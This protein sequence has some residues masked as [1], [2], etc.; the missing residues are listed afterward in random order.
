[1]SENGNDLEIL[2]TAALDLKKTLETVKSQIKQVQSSLKSE[3]IE[4][5]AGLSNSTKQNL[6]KDLNDVTNVKSDG[7]KQV[8]NNLDQVGR[9][10][11]TTAANLTLAHQAIIGLER[12]ARTMVTT[13][14]ELDKQ[15][16]GLRMVTGDSYDDASRLV[17][18]Y[19]V[20]ARELGS[21][22]AQVIDAAD[23]WL[24][25]GK[26]VSETETLIQQSM[27]LSKVGAMDSAMATESL[28]SAMKGYGLAVDD[29]AGIVD[30]LTAIDLKAAVTASD[31]AT[32]MSR[33]A[34]SANISGVKM[35][36]LLGYIAT[37]EEV[38]QKSAETIGNSFQTI[39]ARMGNVK[40]GKFLSDDGEDLSDVEKILSHFGIALRD[41]NEQ[42]RDFGEV[43]DDVAAKWKNF[44][45]VDQNALATTIAGTRQREN[46]LVLM[47]NYSK[48]ME[49]AAV[50]AE[51]TGTAQ[52]KFDAYLDSMEAH[53]NTL[54]ASAEALAKQT[55]STDFLNGL[56]DAG[57]AILDFV[58]NA[59]L[60]TVALTALGTAFAIKGVASFVDTVKKAYDHVT[61]LSQAFDILSKSS[62]VALSADEFDKLLSVTKSLNSSQMELVVTNQALTAEQRMALLTA[63][64]LTAEEAKQ[65]LTTMGLATAEGTATAATFSLSGA[66][67]ALGAAIAANP[68]GLIA[69][70]LTATITVVSAVNRHMDELRQATEEASKAFD[71]QCQSIEDYK[72]KI[73]ELRGEL[74]SGNLSE[75]EAYDKRQ[76]L[77]SIQDEIV[78]KLGSEAG[79]FNILKDS[80]DSVNAAL[81]GFT[82][83]EARAVLTQNAREYE[84]AVG[85]MERRG[86]TALTA[87]DNSRV[88]EVF[89]EVFGDKVSFQEMEN[90]QIAYYLDVNA[91]DA[92]EGLQKVNDALYDL[93]KEFDGKGWD[94]NN[95]LDLDSGGWQKKLAKS[96]ENAQNVI[97]DYGTNYNAFIQNTIRADEELLAVQGKVSD[98]AEQ[99]RNALA[100]GDDEITLSLYESFSDILTELP[101]D[102]P[103]S[104]R[105]YFEQLVDDLQQESEKYVLKIQLEAELETDESELRKQ[106]EQRLKVFE[107]ED[108]KVKRSSILLAGQ[109]V[110]AH[111]SGSFSVQ[112]VAY[113]NLAEAADEYGVSVEGL[114][115]ILV[116]LG[117]VVGDVSSDV[118]ASATAISE[119]FTEAF[120]NVKT[121]ASTV[122]KALQEQG[123]TGNLSL[124]TYKE[125]IAVSSDYAN[126]LTAENGAIQLNAEAAQA[127]T[128]KKIELEMAQIDL[129]KAL[130][131]EKWKE[132]AAAIRELEKNLDSLEPA[133]KAELAALKES[134]AQLQDNVN[135][136]NLMK[137]ELQDL[138]SVYQNWV[139]AQQLGS[140]E[141]MYDS[142][143]NAKSQ[144][145]DALQTGKTGIGNYTYQAALKLMVPEN[146]R[147]DVAAYM[148]TLERYFADDATG[149]TNFA[150]DIKDKFLKE[151]ENGLEIISGTT[152]E[153]IADE[154]KIVPELV[155]SMFHALE[156]YSGNEFHF[157]D[158]DIDVDPIT[159]KLGSYEQLISEYNA[160]IDRANELGVDLDN[161]IYGNI[162]TNNRQV[163]EWT[164]ENL[165]LY[166]DAI[167][168]WGSTVDELRGSISTVFGGSASFDDVE[169]AFSPI[170][171][172]ENGPVLL[173][174]NT[175][176]D[177]I[178]GLI[179]EAGD[180]WTSEDLFRLDTTGLEL[181]GVQIK[182]LLADI[183]E[184]A[185]ATGEAMHFTGADGAINT[186]LKEISELELKL[187]TES[188]QERLEDVDER[189]AEIK[190]ELA[191]LATQR[192][193]GSYEPISRA[194]QR[195]VENLVSELNQLNG[196]RIEVKAELVGN[197]FDTLAQL[198]T[199]I[200]NV[201]SSL[202][203]ISNYDISTNSY[204]AKVGESQEKVN[205]L[206]AE[207]EKL[208]DKQYNIV[209]SLDAETV[210]AKLDEISD[211]IEKKQTELDTLTADVD[212]SITVD[213]EAN[214]QRIDELKAEIEALEQEQHQ[215]EVATSMND[216]ADAQPV[217]EELQKIE[218]FKINDKTFT[219]TAIDKATSIVE[220]IQKS[221][222]SLKDKTVTVTTKNVTSG[223]SKSGEGGEADAYGTSS[224]EGGKTLVG[225]RG[226]ELVVS[227]N[228]Y[229]TVGDYGAE[230]VDLK[231]GDIVF[232]HKDTEKIFKGLSGAQGRALAQGNAADKGISGTLTIPVGGSSKASTANV[233]A[234]TVELTADSVT[235][236]STVDPPIINYN[237]NSES[238]EQH[239]EH[240][241]SW[242][243][244]LPQNTE[245]PDD[246]KSI[247]GKLYENDTIQSNATANTDDAKTL[248]DIY[249]ERYQHLLAIDKISKQDYA[250]WLSEAAPAA[251]RQNQISGEDFDQ[252][253]EE[254][255]SSA[256][257]AMEEVRKLKETA[258]DL[259]EFDLN[260][261]LSNGD[262]DAIRQN[263]DN[264]SAAY[265][266]MQRTLHEQAEWYR[267]SGYADNSD[268]I[269][270]LS[271]LW[272]DYE[273]KRVAA[274]IDA[275]EQIVG[276][277]YDAVDE[278]QGVYET[279]HKAADEYA[280]MGGYLTVDTY[281]EIL[282]LGPQYMQFLRDENGELKIEEVSIRK[283]IA[284]KTRQMA[285][286]TA[287]TY[288][289]RLR[290]SLLGESNEKLETLLY[291]TQ[292]VTNATWDLVYAQL[293]SL[294]GMEGWTAEMEAA[295]RHN[296]GAIYSLGEAA[297]LGIGRSADELSEKLNSM[298][299]GLDDLLKYIM[300]MLKQRI[301]DQIE[302]LEDM[303]DAYADVIDK[304]KE[305]LKLAKAED[306]YQKKIK[307]KLKEMAKL[308]AQID[309]LGMDDSREAQAERAKLIEQL[310]E[311][312]EDVADEQRD[313]AI[314]AQED[315]LDEM[316]KAYE[317]EKDAEI[318]KLEESISST[319]KLY[320]MAMDYLRNDIGT[321]YERLKD[322][323]CAW[324]YEVGSSFEY[325]IVSAWEKAIEAAQRYGD[326]ITAMQML[327][328]EIASIGGSS[329]G[330]NGSSNATSAI[331]SIV[332]EM[333]NNAY[334]WWVVDETEKKRLE[335]RNE[336]LA[337]ELK[338]LG[339]NAVKS[340]GGEWYVDEIGGDTLFGKYTSTSSTVGASTSKTG[341]GTTG[342]TTTGTNTGGTSRTPDICVVQENGSAPSGMQAGD[343]VVT[344]GGL[345]RI[346]RVNS[347]GSYGSD[348][349]ESYA[350]ATRDE[351]LA[352]Y[353]ETVANKSKLP[354]FSAG[355]V[356]DYDGIA[357]VH[358]AN[359]AE[360]VLN[361]RDVGKLYEYIHETPSLIDD[362]FSKFLE[363]FDKMTAYFSDMDLLPALSGGF[364]DGVASA[365]TAQTKYITNNQS[366][367]ITNN[368]GDTIINGGN[369]DTVRQHQEVSRRFV[370]EV[371]KM[372]GV[373]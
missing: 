208:S 230:F 187:N 28:T 254:I 225:E 16:T 35:D 143:A 111:T 88:R 301:E 352:K 151:T 85:Q 359:G 227:G 97:D 31:L 238:Y 360:M 266:D 32:A 183:G 313:Y 107:D 123:A 212:A 125:L 167:E 205:A 320:R 319:E 346:T 221:L 29:V 1:M 367:Q 129:Q 237:G 171:Q 162:N 328:Q 286:D 203:D 77:L 174:E 258:V 96:M 176:Y 338:R 331:Q 87:A 217:T 48:A 344:A 186:L 134:N 348:L 137:A 62:D 150:N 146:M 166:K 355:G 142:L 353:R 343:Y 180:N 19:N 210:Q 228:R 102:A 322:E 192:E 144:I 316:Q 215:I 295:A 59:N 253:C 155:E 86:Y 161:T 113:R 156:M 92:V 368:F 251:L 219:V 14:A 79:A 73:L 191:G 323:L 248:F 40:L 168:S 358:G 333:N 70:V 30:K 235:A 126:C 350:L 349:V 38:T 25:Q 153:Q 285:V 122:S 160:L 193:D 281:Q 369:A 276:A 282:K 2:L 99:F 272:W 302:A 50:A 165:S 80:I 204:T 135:Q 37:V 12:A 172:T 255:L 372:A 209:M 67:K 249:Y 306:D 264:I 226:R 256:K 310:A 72:S 98:A 51:S 239:M 115:D 157:G 199:E 158:V 124:D 185:A 117:L 46:F 94:L 154:L 57:S 109:D 223:G 195:K 289:E 260:V 177:Y 296:I 127:L 362:R 27:I 279:L 145:E 294:R 4:I 324:N 149:L 119:A 284:A 175:V 76:Q 363:R 5:D 43:L 90:G 315:A 340:P 139:N 84:K 218:D 120:T 105:N 278:I 232:N 243:P 314:D 214:Q 339:V 220:S 334:L 63:S 231:P 283:V 55:V 54:I 224:A 275:W 188:A 26:S 169:I 189:I 33:T 330:S 49:Y 337:A 116:D 20:L 148:K 21:T 83:S 52:E 300:A 206:V 23:E 138:T 244:N 170:L 114:L 236:T 65:T 325:E 200:D 164:E 312:Q 103:D 196:E 130:D 267:A 15:L 101:E 287:M 8:S 68:I 370:N 311:L 364:A 309:I 75:Q 89:T 250:N 108:G 361:N 371:L 47:E 303:K 178:W 7:L 288:V 17:D 207:L 133:Q 197:A 298:Q 290:A 211:Q 6:K 53:Y 241:K 71:E 22:T 213:V 184:T 9:K 69:T 56:M 268:E 39:F 342:T 351:V 106:I 3:K 292:D 42:F 305:S 181:D 345:Y 41:N 13:A 261:A 327:P 66:F 202:D 271:K 304:R 222:D 240:I 36:K 132:N 229:Y 291:A 182:N 11:T 179:D 259:M 74:D 257:E 242:Y 44:S 321:D 317:K 332:D 112:E 173:D 82:A 273:E 246:I 270:E 10:A 365:A 147:D 91:T 354:G 100:G 201:K 45:N 136:Y 293:E 280:S 131:I 252:Y 24:R 18:S 190:D 110:A 335:Q 58:T 326:L 152:I 277:A 233:E 262:Y 81:D 336:D 60:L 34:N 128:D 61:R 356:I 194:D 118:T 308:Q 140:S 245:K 307:D 121:E 318:D 366:T 299:D 78:S 347:D 247:R 64:G 357:N 341:I 265:A 95:V 104:V 274:T 373:K 93:E 141:D 163:L 216:G 263:V 297:V 234:N 159:K 198:Q 329:S 269:S